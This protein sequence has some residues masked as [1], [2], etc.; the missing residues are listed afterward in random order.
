MGTDGKIAVAKNATPVPGASPAEGGAAAPG[1]DIEARLRTI[2]RRFAA[3]ASTGAHVLWAADAEGHALD[4]MHSWHAYTGQSA[5]EMAGTGWLTALHPEDREAQ[6]QAWLRA[7]ATRSAYAGEH[8]IRGAD[9]VYRAFLVRGVPVL[10]EH[11]AL[12]EYVGYCTDLS[13]YTR[14]DGERPELF[15]REREA[16]RRLEQLGALGESA[17]SH[18]S[19][20]G[21]LDDALDRVTTLL[22]VETVA[23]LL[24]SDD[25]R[26]LTVVAARGLDEA[27]IEPV[28][29][30]FGEGFAG[31][32]AATRK[33]LIV[34]DLRTFPVVSPILRERVR[35]AVGVPLMVEG[36]V[37]GVLH[38]GTSYPRAF[39][40]DDAA[41]LRLAS[42]RI[43]L[44]I[45]H[46]RLFEAAL[47]AREQA[48]AA[49]AR[50]RAMLEVLPVG[51]DLADASGAVIQRNAA[52]VALWGE[53][54]LVVEDIE[55]YGER[56]GWRVESGEQLSGEA[57]PLLR[58]LLRGETTVNE[59]LAIATGDGRSRTVIGNAAPV[60]DDAGRIAGAVSAM[61][62]ITERKRLEDERDSILSL[63]SHE[64]KTPLTSLKARAQMT[65]RRLVRAGA[66]EAEQLA[67]IE[68]D[69]VRSE[70]LV[71]DLLD[72]SR[73]ETGKLD[74]H[75]AHC[76]LG[77]LCQQAVDEQ[78]A[79]TGR[80]V[81]FEPPASPLAVEVD[82]A[83]VEQVL[84]NLLSNA[85]KYSREDTPVV[86][87]LV[88]EGRTARATVRDFGQGIPA[89]ALPHV[90]DRFYRVV[91]VV[92]QHGP[93]V[94]LGLGLYLCRSLLL[95]MGGQIGAESVVGEGS[96]F[97]FTLPLLSGPDD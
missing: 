45:D 6:R 20:D 86:V 89:E 56:V 15:E 21:L 30:P 95:R 75:M 9:G 37:L 26:F 83:R 90:F 81:T 55:R 60:R 51:V 74:L 11:G 38:V 52:G 43:A 65:R 49:S 91:D 28:R 72:A 85:L 2:E 84:A 87:S 24:R 96:T 40:E 70:R 33:P 80:V 94:G 68:H 53:D 16:L 7:V 71:N 3:L 44:A 77:A 10:D 97:W 25:G 92:V 82:G 36:R 48:E 4:D 5:A 22:R 31:R 58:A 23:I 8:R 42:D 29:V 39:G 50:L 61:V 57:W 41:L 13:L 69:I 12:R 63:V 78:I 62:D 88:R 14:S 17:L 64:L 46:A 27:M 19:T 1:A 67:R 59:E 66:P 47:E 34:H 18:L 93:S 35:S 79:G 54:D 32:I 73:V 76:E